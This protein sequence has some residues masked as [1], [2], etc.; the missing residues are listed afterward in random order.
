MN[1]FQVKTE[2]FAGPLDLLLNLIEK[3]KLLINDLS[4][5]SITDDYI[6]HLK[7]HNILSVEKNSN[8]I[9]VASTLLLIKSKSLLPTLEL[10][11]DEKHDI[12]DLEKRLKIYKR[13]KDTESLILKMFGKRMSYFAN[14]RKQD[15]V[16]FVPPQ[17]TKK[18]D[19]YQSIKTIIKNLPKTE[20]R[21]KVVVQKIISLET[22][23]NQ[24]T[25]RVTENLN[26]SFKEFSGYGKAEKVNII[27]GFLAMLELVKEGIIEAVQNDNDDIQMQTK[28]FNTPKYI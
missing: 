3:R 19:L 18:D 7:N 9:L 20:I 2:V 16:F 17:K 23:I 4:L 22:M 27:V 5:A 21:P 12:K 15:D 14:E 10:S 28:N 24:L 6:Q 8:F 25:Q 1:D 26:M 13:I 11:E